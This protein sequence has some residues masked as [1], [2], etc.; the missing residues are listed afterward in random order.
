[1]YRFEAE[2][3]HLVSRRGRV[4]L[5]FAGGAGVTGWGAEHLL[6][7]LTFN[8]LDQQTSHV[9]LQLRLYRQPAGKPPENWT[10]S[11]VLVSPPP[12]PARA[13]AGGEPWRKLAV[14]VTPREVRAYWEGKP[15]CRVPAALLLR[16]RDAL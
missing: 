16:E 13:P 3:R 5:F 6:C 12:T 8:D 4:G 10:A 1:S 15:L 9:A 11:P 2:V 14:E 7:D